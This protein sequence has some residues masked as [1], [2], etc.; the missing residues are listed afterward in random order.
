MGETSI[1]TLADAGSLLVGDGYRTKRSEHGQP[2]YRILRVADVLDGRVDLSGEDF[3]HTDHSRAIGAKL[4]EPGDVLL[5]TKGTV[6]R[7]A[8]YPFGV[9]RVVYSPQLCYFRVRDPDVLHARFLGYWF[10][11]PAFATQAAHRANNTDMAAYL[12]LRDIRSLTLNLPPTPEQR[13]IAEVLGALDDKIAANDRVAATATSLARVEFGRQTQEAPRRSTGEVLMPVLGGTPSRTDTALWGGDVRW[14]SVKDV[15]ASQYGVLLETSETI[16]ASA[17]QTTRT[18]ALPVGTVVLTAR[19][20][21]GVVARMVVPTAIN[22]SCYG[23]V[24]NVIP[25][26][27]LFL[28]IEDVARQAK[29]MVHGSVFDTITMATFRHVTIPDL[30]ISEWAYIETKVRPA[31]DLVAQTL[32]ESQ[33][34]TKTRDTLLPLLMSGRV[35]VKDAEKLAEEVL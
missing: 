18:R 23:F 11:S 28:V 30:S 22:Q 24:P 25:S 9:E 19:G 8:H 20:T 14:A 13:A 4:S 32:T 27:S 35:R 6:G 7:V 17:T 1:G 15:T 2:G 31:L 5:T 12:N 26:G 29:A 21:V 33:S 34:L 16:T 10:K 3:V